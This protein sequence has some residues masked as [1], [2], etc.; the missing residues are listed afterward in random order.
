MHHVYVPTTNKECIFI[1]HKHFHNNNNDD[2]DDD[3][4]KGERAPCH[5]ACLAVVEG[6]HKK[7]QGMLGTYTY[8]IR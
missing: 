7:N 2:D 5:R 1:C 4:E 6:K 8:F 3:N